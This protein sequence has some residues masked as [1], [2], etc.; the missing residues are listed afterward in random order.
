MEGR[1]GET[2]KMEGR[3]RNAENVE[4]GFWKTSF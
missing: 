3:K 2:K 4:E 1:E